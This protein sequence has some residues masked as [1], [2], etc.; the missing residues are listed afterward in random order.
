[1]GDRLELCQLGSQFSRLRR[2]AHGT[3]A[4]K[5]RALP[6]E[7]GLIR[8]GDAARTL[9]QTIKILVQIVLGPKL[10][11]QLIVF[12]STG[13]KRVQAIAHNVE[14][15]AVKRLGLGVLLS[16]QVKLGVVVKRF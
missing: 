2:D 15:F 1:M 5:R 13:G 12:V 8:F 4:N 7:G 11:L 3:L 16:E 6:A 9:R 10:P 14:R